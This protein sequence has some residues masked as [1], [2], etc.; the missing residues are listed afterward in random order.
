MLEDCAGVDICSNTDHEGLVMAALQAC[1]TG[2]RNCTAMNPEITKVYCKAAKETTPK[3]KKEKTK[4]KTK[5]GTSA[6]DKE[7]MKIQAMAVCDPCVLENEPAPQG[8]EGTR[9]TPRRGKRSR[10][11]RQI[12][13][14][15]DCTLT[16]DGCQYS[17]KLD[18][19]KSPQRLCG[20]STISRSQE[21]CG[22]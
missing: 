22:M 3:N 13:D 12:I 8:S 2:Q 6:S 9:Q 20:Y 16:F 15:N 11:P 21:S 18:S 7:E 14:S 4:T 19:K 1:G 10:K 5:T 17:V